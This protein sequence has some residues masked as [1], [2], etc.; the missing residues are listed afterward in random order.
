VLK[1]T[2]AHLKF[3]KF[4]R[5]YA[6]GPPGK[7]RERGKRRG[8]GGE[9]KGQI[10]QFPHLF[11]QQT[12]PAF[13]SYKEVFICGPSRSV[14]LR[15]RWAEEA[16]SF[17]NFR[18]TIKSKAFSYKRG[19]MYISFAREKTVIYREKIKESAFVLTKVQ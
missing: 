9:G 10:R 15:K 6:P 17:V 19:E 2:Y 11:R 5:G 3:K 13:F 14:N 16:I 7:D 18:N 12:T 4:F 1:L 8:R